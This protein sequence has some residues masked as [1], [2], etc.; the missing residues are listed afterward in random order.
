MLAPYVTK[1]KPRSR[2]VD[3]QKRRQSRKRH[4]NLMKVR[5]SQTFDEICSDKGPDHPCLTNRD[6]YLDLLNT[7]W[8]WL[9]QK[10]EKY[11]MHKYSIDT[12]ENERTK[13]MN[14]VFEH[15]DQFPIDL[16]QQV[17]EL[18]DA[19][20]TEFF[21]G[22]PHEFNDKLFE[23]LID[24]NSRNGFNTPDPYTDPDIPVQNRFRDF[25]SG[26][27][28]DACMSEFWKDDYDETIGTISKMIYLGLKQAVEQILDGYFA[29]G[30]RP[31]SE[32]VHFFVNSLFDMRRYLIEIAKCNTDNFIQKT[33]RNMMNVGRGQD[34][35]DAYNNIINNPRY[36][37]P[38]EEW[39]ADALI[40]CNFIKFG[41]PPPPQ[42]MNPNLKKIDWEEAYS[43]Y[44]EDPNIDL[45]LLRFSM[46]KNYLD[47]YNITPISLW[48]NI[49]I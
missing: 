6:V 25:V 44:E 26:P 48:D 23:T 9:N 21:D 10:F 19:L 12:T 2:H 18:I 47:D 45:D 42:L 11:P 36:R 28:T 43:M 40:I 38:T 35:V 24:F 17:V 1:T 20:D 15:I 41:M 5:D 49:I 29:E 7:I 34:L 37:T 3:D 39:Y 13:F 33:F 46:I 32:D 14:M 31:S 30:L 27:L 8:T 4:T 16:E 22:Q